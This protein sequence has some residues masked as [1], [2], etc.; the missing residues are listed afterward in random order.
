V[1]ISEIIL[2]LLNKKD[3]IQKIRKTNTE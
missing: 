3:C 2:T 1:S